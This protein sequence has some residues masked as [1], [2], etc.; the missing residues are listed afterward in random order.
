MQSWHLIKKQQSKRRKWAAG[1]RPKEVQNEHILELVCFQS[2]VQYPCSGARPRRDGAAVAP[3]HGP[4]VRFISAR[5]ALYARPWPKMA[6]E[7]RAR[8]WNS[9]LEQIPVDFTHNPR[10]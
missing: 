9:K 3:A 7:A 1:R 6:R 5:A 2:V 10:A 8:G 4:S